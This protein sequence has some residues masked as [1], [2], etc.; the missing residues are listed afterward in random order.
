MLKNNNFIST[1]LVSGTQISDDGLTLMC[2]NMNSGTMTHLDISFCRE[3]GDFGYYNINDS[4]C[5]IIVVDVYFYCCY[6]C[7]SCYYCK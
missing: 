1:L 3:I 4:C 2:N 6:C 5:C 7:Y